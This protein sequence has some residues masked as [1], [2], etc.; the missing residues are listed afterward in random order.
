MDI[1]GYL[2][3]EERTGHEAGNSLHAEPNLRASCGKLHV[4]HNDK[5]VF[6]V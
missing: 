3:G 2:L 5:F 4:V 6:I 1:Y